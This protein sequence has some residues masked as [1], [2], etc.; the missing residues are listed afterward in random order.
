MIAGNESR[1]IDATSR[2][3]RPADQLDHVV[4][5]RRADPNLTEREAALLIEAGYLVRANV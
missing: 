1:T 5:F 2:G 4:A 3:G